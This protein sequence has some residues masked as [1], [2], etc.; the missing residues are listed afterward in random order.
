VEFKSN[1]FFIL[2]SIAKCQL[3]FQTGNGDIVSII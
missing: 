2:P 3:L 1:F